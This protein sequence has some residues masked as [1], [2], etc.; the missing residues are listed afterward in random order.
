MTVIT[1]KATLVFNNESTESNETK[2]VINEPLTITKTAV[3]ANYTQD[4]TVTYVV[5]LLNNTDTP[6]NNLVLTDN[7]GK[8]TYAGTDLTPLTYTGNIQYFTNGRLMSQPVASGSPLTINDIYVPASGSATLVYETETNHFAPLGIQNKLTNQV[9]V[10]LPDTNKVLTAETTIKVLESPSLSIIKEMCPHIVP[11]SGQVTY[12]FT[13]TNTGNTA[14]SE[15]DSVQVFDTFNPVLT[16]LVVSLNGK[17]L[18]KDMY[19]YDEGTGNSAGEF[20]TMPKVINVDAATFQRG[21]MNEIVVT[22]GISIL[23]V[24]GKI[25]KDSGQTICPP[26]PSYASKS[27]CPS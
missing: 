15:D 17:N 1:N 25:K 2:G 20:Y 5:T 27:S 3:N 26:S 22:P 11:E 4:G 16:D 23:T 7:L 14:T 10:T 8:Y 12:T 18:S 21:T 9:S 24:T 6:Y 13:I 19:Y